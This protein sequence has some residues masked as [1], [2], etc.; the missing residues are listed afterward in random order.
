MNKKKEMIQSLHMEQTFHIEDTNKKINNIMIEREQL[1]EQRNK[2]IDNLKR[3]I[4]SKEEMCELEFSEQLKQISKLSSEDLY[5]LAFMYEAGQVFDK[6]L[7]KA[8]SLYKIASD[9]ANDCA[10]VL[11]ISS[12]YWFFFCL[13]KYIP[14]KE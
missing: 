14:S 8:I 4:K 1:L 12:I 3:K 13:L 10:M 7:K 2:E 6:N 5:N 9:K 11:Q